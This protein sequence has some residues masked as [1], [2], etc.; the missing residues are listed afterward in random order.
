MSRRRFR[1]RVEEWAE[2]HELPDGWTPHGLREVLQLAGFDD[3]VSD[4]E[5]LEMAVM[6]LQDLEE[7]EAGELV[8]E[9]VFGKEMGSGVRQNLVDDLYGDRPWEE[10]ADVDKQAGLFNTIVLLQ[11]AFPRRFGI[12]DAVRL[13]LSARA[14]DAETSAWLRDGATGPLLLRLLAS[15]M[16]D[17]AVLNRLYQSEL[18]SHTFPNAGAILWQYCEVERSEGDEPPTCLYELHSSWQWLGPL[19]D[20][21]PW[22]GEGWPDVEC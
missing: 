15:G 16:D 2:I 5:A 1:L 11:R 3:V 21:E 17:S 4:D 19:E 20:R 22:E 14:T 18:A 7:Q 10:F 8:L 6:A 13:Q 9:V 12:P